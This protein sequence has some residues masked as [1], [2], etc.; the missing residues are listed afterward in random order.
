MPDFKSRDDSVYQ[1]RLRFYVTFGQLH[2]LRDGYVVIYAYT[3]AGARSAA[4]EVLGQKWASLSMQIPD[5]KSFPEGTCGR[6]IV[7]DDNEP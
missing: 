2:P 1:G 7:A 6:P 3:E 4:F 5:S